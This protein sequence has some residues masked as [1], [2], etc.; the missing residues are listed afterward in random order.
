MP[1]AIVVGKPR[2]EL[3]GS[4]CFDD[5]DGAVRPRLGPLCVEWHREMQPF[6]SVGV[7][8]REQRRVGH[9]EVCLVERHLRG[10]LRKSLFQAVA[11]EFDW[12]QHDQLNSDVE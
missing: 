12:S 10:V 7:Q 11:L 9:V 1:V 4:S 3:A 6:A 2:Q 5:C 8:R